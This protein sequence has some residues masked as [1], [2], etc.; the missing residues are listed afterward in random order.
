MDKEKKLER[1]IKI[2]KSHGIE[3][4]V[5]GCGCCR[6]PWVSF[7]YNSEVILNDENVV[8]FS[9]LGQD[10]TDVEKALQTK[11]EEA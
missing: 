7:A 11:A 10:V 8:C 5:G 1:I 2:L 3:M 4:S 6:S 9:T